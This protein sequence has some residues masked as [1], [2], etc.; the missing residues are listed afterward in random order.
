MLLNRMAIK[1]MY[2]VGG[3]G[4]VLSPFRRKQPFISPDSSVFIENLTS[5]ERARANH[6]KNDAHGRKDAQCN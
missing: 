6:A 3:G 4:G 1:F 2:K 5:S